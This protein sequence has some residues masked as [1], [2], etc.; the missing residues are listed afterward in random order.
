M[1]RLLFEHRDGTA[2]LDCADPS[3]VERGLLSFAAKFRPFGFTG[4]YRIEADRSLRRWA[5][6]MH[7]LLGD[8]FH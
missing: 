4:E 3:E 2:V 1:I 6:R 8:T 7:A 5:Q